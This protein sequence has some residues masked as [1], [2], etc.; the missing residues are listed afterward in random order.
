MSDLAHLLRVASRTFAVGIERLPG[1]LQS[2]VRTAYLLLR[3]SDYLEDNEAMEPERKARLLHLWAEVLEGDSDPSHLVQQIGP[4]S[5]E[6][7]D[8]QVAQRL[9]EVHDAF[10]KCAPAARD[11]LRKHVSDTSRGMARWAVRGDDFADEADL[12]DYMHEVAGRVGYLLTD[13]FVEHYPALAPRHEHLSTLGQRFGLGLQTVN[14]IRGLHEDRD[15]EWIF[16]PRSFLPPTCPD[17]RALFRPEHEEAAQEVLKR[18]VE[19][20]RGHLEDARRY[21]TALPRTALGVRVFCALPLLFAVRTLA[22]SEAN[23]DVFHQEV[24]MT[25]AEVTG[26]TARAGVM[27]WSNEWIRRT[28]DRLARVEADR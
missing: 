13:L 19:K 5:E 11:I 16:V 18:L 15:R 6:T 26:L 2:E 24:K 22:L 9:L 25:R 12:D 3:V 1:S 7:P 4:V 20:A 28:A 17:V 10:L 23:P 14:V 27:A 21:T 8:A